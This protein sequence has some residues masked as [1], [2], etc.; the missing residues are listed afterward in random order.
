[1]TPDQPPAKSG[2]IVYLWIALGTLALLCMCSTFYTLGARRQ[3]ATRDDVTGVTRSPL[4]AVTP[5]A[6][7]T[8]LAGVDDLIV[9][10]GITWQV[11]AAE[12]LGSEFFGDRPTADPLRTSGV[13]VRVLVDVSNIGA[14]PFSIPSVSLEDAAGREFVRSSDAAYRIPSENYCGLDMLNPGLTRSC[15]FVFEAPLD[16][17]GL[18]LLVKEP[19]PFAEHIPV[20]L[21]LP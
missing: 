13:F 6:T 12:V 10:D 2:R 16:A 15:E 5:R 18:L 4:T 1:M 9:G 8:A 7:P 14:E 3:D 17:T 19:G 20:D 21:G 11:R